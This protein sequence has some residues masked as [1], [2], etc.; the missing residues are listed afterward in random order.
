MIA[1]VI[2]YRCEEGIVICIK[3]DKVLANRQIT[4][5]NLE[6]CNHE[7]ADTWLFVH[8]QDA[9]VTNMQK[10]MIIGNDT[11]IVVIALYIFCDLK[12]DQ[13]LIEYG[14]RKNHWWLSVNIIWNC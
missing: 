9:A 11:D 8:A 13:P 1:D 7:E 12:I 5:S 2:T 3:D 4:K 10:V 6:S 14:C